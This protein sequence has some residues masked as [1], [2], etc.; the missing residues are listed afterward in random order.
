M[1]PKTT[2]E[3]HG[4]RELEMTPVQ[5]RKKNEKEKERENLMESIGVVPAKY[6][7][8]VKLKNFRSSRVSELG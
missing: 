1:M 7:S 3:S 5:H 8:K 4:P 6:P 2:S